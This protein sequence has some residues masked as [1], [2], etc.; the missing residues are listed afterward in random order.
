[1]MTNLESQL[2]DFSPQK[3]AEALEA[4]IAADVQ[5]PAQQEVV[6][7][8][9]HTFFSFNAYGYSPM[10]LAWLA[11]QKGFKALGIVD[12]DVLD[13]VDEFLDACG[14]VAVRGSA[15][16]ETRV[17]I[18]EFSTREINSPGEPGIYYYMGIG[19]TSSQAPV[20]VA[21]ILADMRNRAEQRN[22]VMVERINAHLSPVTVDYDQDVLPLTPAGNATERHLLSAYVRAAAKH[23]ADP[24][25]FWTEK[26]GLSEEQVR[27]QIGDVPKFQNTIRARLMKR[28]GVGYTQP[29]PDTFPGME[30][31]NRLIIA[32]GALPCATWLDGMSAG[33]QSMEE[34]LKLLIVRGVVALNIIPDRNWNIADPELRR[35]KVKKLYEVVELAQ[36]FDLPLNIG[37]EMNS[38]GQKLA[39][40][41]D[42]PE[43]APLREPFLAGAYFIYGHTLMQRILGLGYQSEWAK[44]HLPTRYERNDFYT[45]VGRLVSPDQAG[46]GKLQQFTSAHSPAEMVKRL[47]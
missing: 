16:M 19:F 22:R 21:P 27:A 11:K 4:L 39:D 9:C 45:R 13:G 20:D 7:L 24:V 47:S 33:E 17:Y 14:H 30:E 25:P 41:F 1:M 29:G 28:G 23:F 38:Y 6:N 37:T 42:A 26:L 3:R 44:A 10:G 2:N 32:C 43:L 31:V 5:L 46:T 15:G 18:P 12:F 40:D 36:K 34:L 8:H 35:G